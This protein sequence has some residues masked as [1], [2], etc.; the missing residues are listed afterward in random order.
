MVESPSLQ[1]FKRQ[2]DVALRDRLSR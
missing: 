2:V 1:K